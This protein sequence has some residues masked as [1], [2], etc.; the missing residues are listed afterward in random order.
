VGRQTVVGALARAVCTVPRRVTE[1]GSRL[2]LC[3]VFTTGP[4]SVG[5]IVKGGDR[6]KV[7][8][9]RTVSGRVVYYGRML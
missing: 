8:E 3:V 4:L 9:Y 6:T 1:Q 5:R 2:Y 7:V